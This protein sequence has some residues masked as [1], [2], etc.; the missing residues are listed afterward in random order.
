M[1]N[2]GW[3]HADVKP[4]NLLVLRLPTPDDRVMETVVVS[5]LGSAVPLGE[6]GRSDSPRVSTTRN[7]APGGISHPD[8]RWSIKAE[9]HSVALTLFEMLTQQLPKRDANHYVLPGAC[10]AGLKHL[11]EPTRR[12]GF[13]LDQAISGR[14][15]SV[16]AF[17]EAARAQGLLVSTEA[18]VV[19][20]PF[21]QQRTV[22][23]VVGPWLKG[24]VAGI[25]VALL[26]DEFGFADDS[27][28]REEIADDD[29]D[30]SPD[31]ED[32]EIESADDEDDEDDYGSNVDD[33]ESSSDDDFD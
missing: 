23:E 4:S 14:F 25:G 20:E 6:A 9:L 19:W 13:L 26:P 31:D 2:K 16:Q 29:E 21:R 18:Q 5:D 17:Y 30:D 1:H 28:Q 15:D 7:Y 32:D 10:Q 27:G 22:R 8:F 24:L 12:W 3:L 11:P 33:Y